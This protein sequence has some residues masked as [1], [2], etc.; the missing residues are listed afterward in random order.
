M[1][2]EDFTDDQRSDVLLWSDE[3][4]RPSRRERRFTSRFGDSLYLEDKSKKDWKKTP[5]RERGPIN[6]EQTYVVVET[7][8]SS[9]PTWG[10]KERRTFHNAFMSYGLDRW[11]DV[12]MKSG[13]PNASEDELRAYG[14]EFV[15]QCIVHADE[16]ERPI[17]IEF[18][19]AMLSPDQTLQIELKLKPD[20]T[21]LIKRRLRTWVR[22][23]K[24]WQKMRDALNDATELSELNDLQIPPMKRSLTKWWTEEEDKSLV[25]GVFKVMYTLPP[26]VLIIV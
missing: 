3:V 4:C 15:K 13:I 20:F 8:H 11:K 1:Q 23:I 25:I 16:T 12:Q 24:I 22:Y 6:I 2:L 5:P 10:D 21:K 9:Y 14:E 19:T 26:H 18:L 17:F 7:H